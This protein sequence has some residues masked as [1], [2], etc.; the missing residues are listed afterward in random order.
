MIENKFASPMKAPVFLVGSER[1]GTTMLR[2]M[3][4]HHP[5]VA[6]QSEFEFSVE[7]VSDDGAFPEIEAYRDWLAL[8]RIF[9]D[10][11]FRIDP[12][13]EFPE[14]VNSFLAQK[15][16]QDGKSRVGATV[17][18]YFDRLLHVWPDARFI[19]LLRDPRDVARSTI[20]MGFAGN[21]WA[22]A[23]RWVEAETTW[24][25]LRKRLT[26]DRWIELRYE[27]LV[28]TPEARLNELCAFLDVSYDSRM[29]EYSATTTYGAP[30]PAVAARWRAHLSER[31]IGLIEAQVG[32]LM[33]DRGYEPSGVPAIEVSAALAR[34][35]R[36]GDRLGQVR[37][38]IDRYG[39][40]L[41]LAEFVA[42]RARIKPLHDFVMMRMHTITRQHL[43]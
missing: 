34:K 9:V 26:E 4:D 39:M 42:R 8:D 27:E 29:L 6:F 14:L 2:L 21:V 40:A 36:W 7:L 32:S 10:S 5:E 17:H 18:R 1:S 20:P 41:F 19:H 23:A 3:L 25:R 43:R 15:M 38:R 24:S 33:R 30:D 11:G 37:F 12:S 22:G 16:Q 31:D 28:R 13:L 35:L